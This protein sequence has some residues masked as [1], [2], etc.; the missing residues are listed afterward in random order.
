MG[1]DRDGK[2]VSTDLAWLEYL[3][4]EL[5]SLA[6]I[7]NE[8]DRIRRALMIC[9]QLGIDKKTFINAIERIRAPIEKK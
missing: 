6:L 7:A 4:D 2:S 5:A 8:R 1:F 9:E 3:N